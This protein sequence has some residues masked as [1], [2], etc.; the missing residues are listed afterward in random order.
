MNYNKLKEEL[1]NKK[2]L[3]VGPVYF[4]YE[5][6][7][8]SI[9][10]GCGAKVDF[11][12]E[13]LDV[14]SVV[15]GLVNKLPVGMCKIIRDVQHKRQ[16][17]ALKDNKYDLV[18]GLRMDFFD[19]FLCG[20]M[21]KYWPEARFCLYFWDSCKNMRRPKEVAKYFDKVSSFD[22]M[23]CEEMADYGWKFRP[24]FY[25]KEYEHASRKANKDIDVLYVSSLFPNR[26]RS[27]I[28]LREYCEKHNLNLKTLF[29]IKESIYKVQK[30]KI[31]EYAAIESECIRHE[32]I[33]KKE[34][35][36]L[37]GRAKVMFDCSHSRQSGLT[38]RTV[39]CVGAEQLLASTNEDLKNYDFYKKENIC[40]LAEDN[41]EGL[42][43][44]VANSEY[45]PL[46][47]EL[48]DKYS[49]ASWLWDIIGA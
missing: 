38:M 33:D 36:E 44:F 42:A 7:I 13:N 49:V 9:M 2:V 6:T 10:E 35:I 18:F 34:I 45:E 17:D 8:I 14:R 1:N 23:D 24:L 15:N 20:L 22:R 30:N 28:G 39:E 32:S 41:F 31:P 47:E 5:K 48:Y 4:G 19:D 26:A 27:Y 29:Y 3:F 11:I 25:I 37:M 21:K 46:N 12:Q 43:E 40:I 16:L